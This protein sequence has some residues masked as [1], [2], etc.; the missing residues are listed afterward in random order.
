MEEDYESSFFG[1][2]LEGPSEMKQER[3]TPYRRMIETETGLEST[4]KLTQE[5]IKLL[6]HALMKFKYVMP[7][8]TIRKHQ[9][10]FQLLKR[11]LQNMM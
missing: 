5:E 1:E 4:T 10:K 8:S 9:D 2:P 3:E 11:K 7:V 6:I